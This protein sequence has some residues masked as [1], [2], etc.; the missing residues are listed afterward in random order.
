MRLAGSPIRSGSSPSPL[1]A[2]TD[3]AH[4]GRMEGDGLDAAAR[5]EA[6]SQI[7]R[8]EA[9]HNVDQH[10]IAHLEADGII[11]RNTIANLETALGSARRIGAAL[12]IIMATQNITEEQ[13]FQVLR[14][15][16]QSRNRKLRDVAEDVLLAGTI[17]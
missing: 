5:A 6:D 10:V 16:S 1:G 12:G 3:V 2:E 15:A 8:L 9:Q 11:D 7:A 17:D 4:T 13:A 14:G